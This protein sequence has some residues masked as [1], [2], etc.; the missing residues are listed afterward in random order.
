MNVI[1]K[2]DF[3]SKIKTF[4]KKQDQSTQPPSVPQ[5]HRSSMLPEQ[6]AP[7]TPPGRQAVPKTPPGTRAPS[8]AAP[9]TPPGLPRKRKIIDNYTYAR[10]SDL[11]AD[12]WIHG[13]CCCLE[14]T[15]RTEI[16][17]TFNA[18]ICGK[19]SR[20]STRSKLS[21]IKFCTTT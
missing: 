3:M 19:C 11:P 6:T 20:L 9:K 13:C 7:K 8:T 12:G 2:I 16:V 18:Y 5:S 4:F 17:S 21:N 15:T 1:N 10:L 14:P